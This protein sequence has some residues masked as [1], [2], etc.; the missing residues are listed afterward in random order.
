MQKKSNSDKND[1]NPFKLHHKG[2]D[3][4]YYTGKL[5]GAAHSIC[6]LRYK[7]PKNFLWYF[8]MVLHMTITSLLNSQQKNLMVS[9]NVQEKIQ[10]IILLFQYQFKK[11]DNG[12]TI[13]YKLKQIALDLCRP[14][15]Q[16][17]LITYLKFTKKNVKIKSVS[18]FLGLNNNRLRYECKE[19]K[20]GG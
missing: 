6:N 5:G 12:E 10:R 19:C 16:I 20:K 18:D 4:C 9:L 13:T 11:I 7:K 17:L 15:Y 3:H 14:H 2:R 1:E 8:I